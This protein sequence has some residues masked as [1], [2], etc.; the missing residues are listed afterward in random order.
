M[1]KQM[2]VDL[3]FIIIFVIISHLELY[4]MLLWFIYVK[5]MA[6]NKCDE[7]LKGFKRKGSRV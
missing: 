6:L 3:I 7:V 1:K 4:Y 2:P 5:Q